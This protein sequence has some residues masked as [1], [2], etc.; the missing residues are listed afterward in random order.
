M[1]KTIYFL[2]L[3]FCISQIDLIAQSDRAI[4]RAAQTGKSGVSKDEL[5]SIKSDVSYASAIQMLGEMARK[6]ED[7]VLIDRSPMRDD[8]RPIGINIE[9]MYWKDALE[10]ILRSNK[11]WYND[12]P[13]YIEILSIEELAGKQVQQP[14]V[15]S[16]QKPLFT[17][18]VAVDTMNKVIAQQREITISSIFFQ[19][20]RTK[21]AE[22]GVSFSIFRGKDLNLGVVLSGTSKVIDPMFTVSATPTSKQLTVDIAAALAMMEGDNLGEVISRPE[23]TVRSGNTGRIQ[24]GTDFSIKEKDFAGNTVERFYPSGT[25]LTV[26]PKIV[27][28]NDIEFVDLNYQIER[29]NVTFTSTSTLVDKTQATGTLSLLNGEESYVGGLY[30]NEESVVRSG[31][32]ILKDLPWWVFGLRYLFGYDKTVTSRKELIVLIKASFLPLIEERAAVTLDDKKN[33]IH[34]KLQES[35]KEVKKRTTVK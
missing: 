12:Y 27:K 26:T 4:R 22:R 30:T 21:L 13:D 32:P 17:P 14:G 11:L 3:L 16:D 33:L 7:R 28:I 8:T 5:V 2:L 6:L 10:L 15:P 35:Q 20:D 25:I 29:S 34:E 31:V 19:L 1:K 23:I 18:A 9:S 24:I